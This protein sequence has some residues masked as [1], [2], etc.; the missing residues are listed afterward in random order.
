MVDDG[1]IHQHGRNMKAGEKNTFF[2]KKHPGVAGSQ[3]WC[4]FGIGLLNLNFLLPGSYGH[5][6]LDP[7]RYFQSFVEKNRCLITLNFGDDPLSHA[8]QHPH[9]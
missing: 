2:H 8:M 9:F 7:Q 4:H 5:Q 6:V 3:H 1:K